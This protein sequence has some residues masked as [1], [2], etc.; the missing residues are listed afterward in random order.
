MVRANEDISIIIEELKTYRNLRD[1]LIESIASSSTPTNAYRLRSL[2]HIKEIENDTYVCVHC[3][4]I[5][6]SDGNPIGMSHTEYDFEDSIIQLDG[7]T[8]QTIQG[9]KTL[10]ADESFNITL[11]SDIENL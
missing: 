4:L 11:S 10:L 6:D 1:E 3:K 7:D 8:S 2:K 9:L 5:K